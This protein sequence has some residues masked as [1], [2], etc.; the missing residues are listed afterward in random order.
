MKKVAMDSVCR[1]SKQVTSKC[2]VNLNIVV[3]NLEVG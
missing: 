2:L 3:P 1:A